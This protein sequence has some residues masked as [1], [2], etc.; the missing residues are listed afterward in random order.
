M[1]HNN[2]LPCLY[3]CKIVIIGLGYVGLPLC[4]ELGKKQKCNL[5][6]AS[7]NRK[8]IGFDI[9]QDRLNEIHQAFQQ[10]IATYDYTGNYQGVFPVKCNQHRHVVEE[11]MSCGERWNFGLEAGSKAELLIA[12]SLINDPQA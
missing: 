10:A 7:L 11:L 8:V 6:N 4:V 1:N 9:N 3:N 2:Y 12:L 5:T